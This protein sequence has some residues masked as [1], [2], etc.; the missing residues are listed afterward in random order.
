[1]G[2]P[3]SCVDIDECAI[4]HG[5]CDSLTTCK[6]FGG[7]FECSA[8]PPGYDGSGTTGCVPRACGGEPEPT[9]ACIRVAPDGDDA[10]GSASGGVEPFRNVDVAIAFAA[11]HRNH[12]QD[13]CV[14]AGAACGAT[15]DYA[16]PAGANLVMRDGISVFA[17]FESTGWTRCTDSSTTLTLDSGYVLSFGADVTRPTTFEGFKTGDIV[18]QAA[19]GAMLRDLEAGNLTVSQDAEVEARGSTFGPVSVVQSSLRLTGSNAGSITLDAARGSVV[20]GTHFS[21]LDASGDVRGIELSYNV[22][23]DASVRDCEGSIALLHNEFAAQNFTGSGSAVALSVE[24]SCEALI[25]SKHDHERERRRRH[26]CRPVVQR[27]VHRERQ[28][29]RYVKDRQSGPAPF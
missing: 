6:N 9:C 22:G 21:H 28:H 14:A 1:L 19:R 16:G 24:G 26:E 11:A 23:G 13:V 8:C 25:D 10:E 3:T 7:G 5:G 27:A 29:D 17:S 18:A 4:D 12:A 20:K 15:T 2:D